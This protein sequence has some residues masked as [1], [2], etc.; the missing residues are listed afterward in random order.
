MKTCITCNTNY[1][2]SGKKFCSQKCMGTFLRINSRKETKVCEQ[3]KKEFIV[4]FWYR[5]NKKL[6]SNKCLL[7]VK[8]QIMRNNNPSCNPITA[9]K[10][11]DKAKERFKNGFV[12]P[13][14]GKKRPDL[15]YYNKMIKPALQKLDKNPNWRGGL[16]FGLYGLDFN[17]EL[18]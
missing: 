3:C 16:S 5:N 2:T 11:S 14:L 12:N 17:N 13:L 15:C 4:P 8:R 9:K 6:C 1:K 7:A 18:K 10:I